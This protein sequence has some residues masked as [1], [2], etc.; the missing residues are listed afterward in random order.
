MRIKTEKILI[1]RFSSIGDVA[2]ALS[3]PSI[4]REL[5]PDAELHFLTRKDLA[6]LA[7]MG[8]ELKQQFFYD[9]TTGFKGLIKLIS[10]LY[11]EKYT[12]IYDC[13]NNLRS[14]LVTFSL[15]FLNALNGTP[16]RFIQRPTHR[17][18]RFILIKFKKNIFAKPFNGQMDQLRPLHKWGWNLNLPPAPVLKISKRTTSPT[19]AFKKYFCLAPSAAYELKRW[20]AEYWR[21]LILNNQH[22]NFVILGGPQDQFTLEISKDLANSVNFSGQLSL[23]QSANLVANSQGLIANDTGLMHIAEQLGVPAI[24]FMGPAPFGFPARPSTLVLENTNLPCR[25]CSKHGQGPC[26]NSNFQECLRSITPTNINIQ[27]WLKEKWR[28][29]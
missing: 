26:V 20:P 28:P 9:K 14:N 11:S 8:N 7:L 4:L 16:L 19:L 1:I 17:L 29:E 24:A 27:T 21:E 6:E 12:R 25:P 22:I 3:V 2:Q 10:Q 18:K 5:F 23:S 13:H 15:F